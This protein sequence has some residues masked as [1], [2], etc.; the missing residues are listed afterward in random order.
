VKI[1]RHK[2]LAEGLSREEKEYILSQCVVDVLGC[3]NGITVVR[4]S[5]KLLAQQLLNSMDNHDLK[6]QSTQYHPFNGGQ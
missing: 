2:V 1:D 6:V 5:P 4:A 3:E